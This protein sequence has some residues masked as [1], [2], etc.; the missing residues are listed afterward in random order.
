MADLFEGIALV[1]IKSVVRPFVH[2]IGGP[3]DRGDFGG[4]G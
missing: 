4:V 3:T 2:L 1:Y